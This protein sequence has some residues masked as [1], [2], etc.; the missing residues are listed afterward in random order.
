[1]AHEDW[2]AVIGLEVH[3]QLATK[4]KL[5][6]GAANRFGDPPNH[7][8]D[9]VVLGMPGVL[10]VLNREAVE[11]AMRVGFAL[12][13]E[14]HRRSRF[15]RKHYFYAD[16]PKGYQIT[17]HR[18]PICTQ[19]VVRAS[20]D[21]EE[22]SF[23]LNRIHLEEDAGKT[24]HDGLRGISRVDF[25]RA[26]VPLI[27]VVSEPDM[28][29]AAE[30]VAFMK[31]LHQIVI[32]VGS[33]HG[34]LEKGHFRC[35]A[36]VSI[37][38]VGEDKLGTRTEMKNINS[39][40]FVGRAVIHEIDR[41]IGLL[42]SGEAIIQQTRLWDDDAGMS[43]AMRSK[44][45]IHDYRYFPDPDLMVV[46]VDESTYERVRSS[47]PEL[48][49]ERCA[50]FESE[51]GLS[52]YDAQLLTQTKE[53]SDYFEVLV[54]EGIDPKKAANW[55]QGEL[56]GSLNRDDRDIDESPVSALELAGLLNLLGEGKLSGKMA[57][58]AFRAMMSQ[59]VTAADWLEI[60]GGQ[61]TDEGAIAE[62]VA[63]IVSSHPAQ[64]AEF[65]AGKEKL[66]G[67]FVG[68][69]MRETRGKA[70]PQVVGGA[71]RKALAE[72]PS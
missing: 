52:P 41:Q 59:G 6:T 44:E 27:E 2:E 68:Q 47:L 46:D 70:N 48:P 65:R 57:K 42:E 43:R 12:G 1:M 71:L 25:N 53:R 58:E 7:N 18:Y 72:E 69:V 16:L 61:I 50:R 37:R 38:P 17:Q 36:N 67:F 49:Q 29:S 23:R 60:H 66:M 9:P 24:I 31:A 13:C 10:P 11:L 33:S 4:S 15:D 54:T 55:I 19:G 34:D 32:A 63:K 20:V 8:V 39:F 40:R 62:I 56:L 45:E 21:G 3:V 30:A 35:D 51:L 14:V 26:G 22:R 28:R 64:A 5:F